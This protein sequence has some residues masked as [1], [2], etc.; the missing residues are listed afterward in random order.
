MSSIIEQFIESVES[1]SGKSFPTV[2]KDELLALWKKHSPEVTVVFDSPRRKKSRC[3]VILKSG[4]HE[5]EECGHEC[6]EGSPMCK[7]HQRF[8]EPKCS[9]IL[10]SGDRKGKKCG[11]SCIGDSAFCSVH[12]HAATICKAKLKSGEHKGEHCGRKCAEGSMYCG[13]HLRASEDSD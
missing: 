10:K 1:S 6:A 12:H 13:I 4:E 11:K 2:T 9:A 8:A 3:S 5:G 7:K